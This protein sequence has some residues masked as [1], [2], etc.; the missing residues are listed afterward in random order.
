MSNKIK[1]LTNISAS[2]NVDIKGTTVVS[3]SK[4]LN[5]DAAFNN[6]TLIT[7]S[8]GMYDLDDAVHGLDS[9][10]TTLKNNIK[11]AYDA[12][13]VV[14]TGTLDENGNKKVNLT[15]EAVSG[16][17]YFTTQS[18]TSVGASVL[19][20]EG[21]TNTYKNDLV[22]FQ[23]FNSA[24]C[25]W[26]EIDAPAAFNDAYRLIVVN[27]GSLPVAEMIGG[28]GGG[29]DTDL[30][31]VLS[32]YTPS[33]GST[34]ITSDGEHKGRFIY[35]DVSGNVVITIPT[36]SASVD[37]GLS[38]YAFPNSFSGT[39][40]FDPTT[41]DVTEPG[42]EK[43]IDLG[44]DI[45][46]T[47]YNPPNG[48]T[49]NTISPTGYDIVNPT[50]TFFDEPPSIVNDGEKIILTMPVGSGSAI[51]V[52]GYDPTPS[53]S[54]PT[55]YELSWSGGLPNYSPLEPTY[56]PTYFDTGDGNGFYMPSK[57]E[58]CPGGWRVPPGAFINPP[59]GRFGVSRPNRSDQNVWSS[60]QGVLGL[61]PVEGKTLQLVATGYIPPGTAIYV[62][63]TGPVSFSGEYNGVIS[64]SATAIWDSLFLH[65]AAQYPSPISIPTNARIIIMHYPVISSELPDYHL[66]ALQDLNMVFG[67]LSW[68]Y[69]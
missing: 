55:I 30:F 44:G 24:S 40:N 50:S 9:G 66:E 12:I 11:T 15:T 18:L 16:S 65:P 29:G 36:F 58:A 28:G 48:T 67:W 41:N 20:D 51:F 26:A 19:V 54:S 5:T 43:I 3:G 59:S 42:F 46:N 14:L 33:T 49:L 6:I 47:Q 62:E 21:G 1:V 39:V 64:G 37:G 13:R 57:G 4:M 25:L 22:F 69:I 2:Q 56:T 7:S 35:P 45:D 17:L 61:K 27:H 60:G 31:I 10:L 34:S 68:E 53:D 32:Y 38:F 23:L 63:W 8:D 52:D